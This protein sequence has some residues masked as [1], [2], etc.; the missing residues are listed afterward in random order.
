MSFIFL[1]FLLLILGAAYLYLPGQRIGLAITMGL[2]Y[3]FWGL[4]LHHK[5]KSL[6]WPIV[7]EYLSLAM[8]GVTLLIFLS[9][10][11]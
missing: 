4:I 8:L 6:H 3:F 9:L 5:D 1:S 7:L 2:I 11:V 10:R